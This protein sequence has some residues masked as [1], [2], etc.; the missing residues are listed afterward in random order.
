MVAASEEDMV[1]VVDGELENTDDVGDDGWD[2]G[3]EMLNERLSDGLEV[4][5]SYVGL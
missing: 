5:C 1:L 4:G 2:R 3:D